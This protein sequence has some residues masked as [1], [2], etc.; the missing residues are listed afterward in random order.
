[1][2]NSKAIHP[3]DCHCKNEFEKANCGQYCNDRIAETGNLKKVDAPIGKAIQEAEKYA[4]KIA[5]H[6][7]RNDAPYF[8]SSDRYEDNYAAFL[9]GH[10]LALQEKDTRIA[11]LSALLLQREGEIE[12]LEK[13]IARLN[14]PF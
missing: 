1:M 10:S 9:A 4:D 3:N 5:P 12:K 11:E 13:Q 6:A 2:S 7:D 14:R 8:T